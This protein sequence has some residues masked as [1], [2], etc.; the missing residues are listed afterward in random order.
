MNIGNFQRQKVPKEKPKKCRIRVR[1]HSDGS[2]TKEVS[3]CSKEELKAMGEIN[4]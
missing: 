1:K 3:G 2:V 4:P